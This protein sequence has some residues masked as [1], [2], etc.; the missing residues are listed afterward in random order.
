MEVAGIL[1]TGEWMHLAAVSGPGGAKLYCNGVLAGTH[2]ST[3][4]F[5]G[6]KGTHNYL[7][8]SNYSSR[9]PSSQGTMDEVRV[10]NHARTA[11]QIRAGMFKTLSGAEK[12]LAGYWNFDDGTAADLSP[13]KHDGVPAGK[14]LFPEEALPKAGELRTLKLAS[15]AGRITGPDGAGADT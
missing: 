12:G 11:E 6:L 2:A 13:G 8:K 10:W 14:P 7:G 4:S 15:L 9:D 1:K 3:A 5:S